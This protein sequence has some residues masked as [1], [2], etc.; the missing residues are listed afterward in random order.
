MCSL[1]QITMTSWLLLLAVASLQIVG[2]QSATTDE[3]NW[4]EVRKYMQ[5]L[6]HSQ[7][8]LFEK[9]QAIANRLGK[10]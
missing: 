9:Y 7:E 4:S 3:E 1:S 2:G 8:R 5:T 6:M 10:S